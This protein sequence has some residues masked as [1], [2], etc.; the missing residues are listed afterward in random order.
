MNPQQQQ[1]GPSTPQ[2]IFPQQQQ[3][4]QVQQQPN[5]VQ[6]GRP[7]VIANQQYQN[8]SYSPH[9]PQTPQQQQQQQQQSQQQQ[10]IRTPIQLMQQQTQKLAASPGNWSLSDPAILLSGLSFLT[11]G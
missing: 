7:I 3:Q 8:R 2:R 5:M 1:Q 4:Q 6:Q 9:A 10:N 11:Y